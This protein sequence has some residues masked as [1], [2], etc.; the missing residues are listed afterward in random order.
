MRGWGGPPETD[1]L[2]VGFKP[3]IAAVIKS[4]RG[5]RIR[6]RQGSFQE[7]AVPEYLRFKDPSSEY[8]GPGQVRVKEMN[9]SKPLKKCRKTKKRCRNWGLFRI[10]GQNLR[11]T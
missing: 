4:H 3:P 8:M 2:G 10:P 11:K 5:K 9:A 6:K 7:K 1:E